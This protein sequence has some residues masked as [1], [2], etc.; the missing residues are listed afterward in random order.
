[1]HTVQPDYMIF[2]VEEEGQARSLTSP[3]SH[4]WTTTIRLVPI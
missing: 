4:A 1:M 2:G 3:V